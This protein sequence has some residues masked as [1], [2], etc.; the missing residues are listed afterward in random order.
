MAT[1]AV[2]PGVKEK[3][4]VSDAG[5]LK[6]CVRFKEKALK[7]CATAVN[8]HEMLQKNQKVLFCSLSYQ[9]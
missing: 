2:M 1:A 7:G 3:R 5:A 9:C 8:L 6:R 4:A